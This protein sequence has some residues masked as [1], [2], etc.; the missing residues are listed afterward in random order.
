M[1]PFDQ[2]WSILKMADVF[3]DPVSTHR[4][5]FY[6][7][8]PPGGATLNE[9]P[10]LGITN[11]DGSA[12]YQN[13]NVTQ[14]GVSE[15]AREGEDFRRGSSAPR[16]MEGLSD[17]S[18]FDSGGR[19]SGPAFVGVQLARTNDER[20]LP[21][22]DWETDF[23]EAVRHFA[24][25]ADH[26][27]VHRMIDPEI[28]DWLKESVQNK[29]SPLRRRVRQGMDELELEKNP[30]S[31][32]DISG[33]AHEYGAY[34]AEAMQDAWDETLPY[35]TGIGSARDMLSRKLAIHPSAEKYFRFL[36][37]LKRRENEKKWALEDAEKN[38]SFNLFG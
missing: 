20:Y 13:P 28:Y 31:L 35:G 34:Q 23:D 27:H 1:N 11:P 33:H 18:M 4:A 38:Q 14:F 5:G 32:A 6:R 37:D 9:R 12:R 29:D 22:P 15:E 19:F 17:L 25:T 10:Y 30:L 2:A 36:R 8:G 21:K 3:I 7:G 24:R 26:E 16:M